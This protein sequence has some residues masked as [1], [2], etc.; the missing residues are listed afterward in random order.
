MHFLNEYSNTFDVSLFRGAP[1]HPIVTSH[2]F[3]NNTIRAGRRVRPC[4]PTSRL[5]NVRERSSRRVAGG[6]GAVSR[7]GRAGATRGAAGAGRGAAGARARYSPRGAAVTCR[8][9]TRAAAAPH[10][11]SESR[12]LLLEIIVYR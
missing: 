7:A 9:G 2:V 5:E 10:P 1:N 6:L 11:R 12:L 3:T 4:S 8:R